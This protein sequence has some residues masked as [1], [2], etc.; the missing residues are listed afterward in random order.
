MASAGAAR[1]MVLGAAVLFSTGAA[2][3]KATDLGAWPVASFRSGIAALVLLVVLPAARRRRAWG[4]PRT[5]LVGCAYALTMVSFVVANKLTTAAATTYLQATAP[6]YVL[7]LGPLLL[8]ERNRPRDLLFMGALAV[9]LALFFVG[10]EAPQSTA[11][12]P[13]TGNLVGVLAGVGWGLTILGLRWLESGEP[14][15]A[16]AAVVVGNLFAFGV[17]L[18]WALPLPAGIE[19]ADWGPVLYLGA[20]QIALAYILLTTGL[21]GVPALEASLLLLL[22]PVLAPF[23]AWLLHDELAGPWALAGCAVILSATVARTVWERWRPGG[24]RR[25]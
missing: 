5:Y 22:E 13:W 12:D 10:V 9:G 23:W 17:A 21:R 11:A 15:A 4:S 6:L 8:K 2:A 14:G 20:V 3:V 7:A 19:A 18:P 16:P 25:R 1:W 24:R